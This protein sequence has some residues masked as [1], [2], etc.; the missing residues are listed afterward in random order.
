VLYF[1]E[2]LHYCRTAKAV[3][4]FES[5]RTAEAVRYFRM[6]HPRMWRTALA[7]RSSHTLTIDNRWETVL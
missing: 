2:R 6:W 5:A 4:Y 7:V 1:E 3:R